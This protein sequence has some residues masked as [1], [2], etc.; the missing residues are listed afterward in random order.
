MTSSISLSRVLAAL[1]Y[2]LDLTEGHPR[3]HTA[4]SCLIGMRI[5]RTLDLPAT[6]REDLF[7]ALLLKDAGCSSNATRVHQ[8]FGGSDHQAKRAVWMRDW[9]L[10]REQFAY[11]LEAVEPDGTL[12]QRFRKFARLAMLGPRGGRELFQIRCDRGAEIARVVGFSAGVAEAIRSMDEHW[13]G[14]GY[15]SGLRGPEIPLAA[16]IIGVAQVV[17]IF[18]G[19][20]GPARAMSV[21]RER[22]GRWFDPELAKACVALEHDGDFWRGVFGANL[23]EAVA[24]AE[25]VERVVDADAAQLDRLARA[26]AWVI[27]AKSAFTYEHSERMADVAWAIG[28]QLG[29]AD[30]DAAA[31]RRV[32]LLHDIGKLAVPNRILDKPGR[33]DEGE[34]AIVKA[35]PRHTFAILDRVPGFREQALEASLHHERLDGRGYYRGFVGKDIGRGARIM[36]V[37]DVYDALLADRP[38]RAGLPVEEVLSVLRKDAGSALCADC[39]G[40]VQQLAHHDGGIVRT[41]T[42]SATAAAA[43]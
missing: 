26:F 9:R 31:L 43:A 25:P 34:W 21:V 36:A 32:A 19:E 24:A 17:E 3:G 27:D 1:S 42:A 11:A 30:A 7:Y 16:R 35:H 18:A 37:A 23:E 20:Y 41:S 14:G 8:L 15:P 40:A 28:R 13:D 38:Y 2:A 12:V 10:F 6:V 39:V 29:M 4:R 33:L 5:A 22:S